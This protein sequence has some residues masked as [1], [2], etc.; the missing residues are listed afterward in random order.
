LKRIG[1]AAT[2]IV[3]AHYFSQKVANHSL[4]SQEMPPFT[5]LNADVIPEQSLLEA[6]EKH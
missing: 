3:T 6:V 4:D 5:T 1:D 2:V